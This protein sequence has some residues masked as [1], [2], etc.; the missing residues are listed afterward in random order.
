M[1]PGNGW[2]HIEEPVIHGCIPV[3]IM[4][5]I[6]VQLEDALDLRRYAVRVDRSELPRLLEKLRAISPAQIEKMQAALRTVHLALA[7]RW[8]HAH[9]FALLMRLAAFCR[10]NT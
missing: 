7:I 1:L 9:S 4:P 8:A 3:V 5:G 6:H 2:G 10:E